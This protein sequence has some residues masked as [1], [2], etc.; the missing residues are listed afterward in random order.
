MN[1]LPDMEK[2]RGIMAMVC[3][4]NDVSGLEKSVEVEWNHRFTNRMGDA[5]HKKMRIRFST[6]LFIRA[7]ED[8]QEQVI[9]HEMAHIVA[10]HKFGNSIKPHGKEWKT[11]MVNAGYIPQVYHT[12]DRSDI[13]RKMKR[14]SVYC[15]CR[16]HHVTT[17]VVN[18]I[19]D[20]FSY[21]CKVCKSKLQLSKPVQII[22][23]Q[24]KVVKAQPTVVVKKLTA[25]TNKP[26]QGKAIPVMRAI[27]V[28]LSTRS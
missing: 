28:N 21:K 24:P 27:S 1:K 18:R 11:A 25:T 9:A 12:I 20:G 3:E 10:R 6:P 16:E 5:N 19:K 8:Q 14:V 2:V 15:S 7:T 4:K 17:R 26:T 22:K 13:A 23:P